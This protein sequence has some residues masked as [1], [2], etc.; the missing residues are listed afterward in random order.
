MQY[1]ILVKNQSLILWAELVNVWLLPS[2][3]NKCVSQ[4]GQHLKKDEVSTVLRIVTVSKSEHSAAYGEFCDE[5]KQIK[6]LDKA[7]VSD[8]SY[9]GYFWY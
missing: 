3:S 7:G 5:A 9:T 8:R 2:T 4:L 1:K 6:E